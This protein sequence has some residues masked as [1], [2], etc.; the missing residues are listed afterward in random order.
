MSYYKEICDV[1]F[2]IILLYFK[3]V[4][5]INRLYDISF[6]RN[7]L[8]I[9]QFSINNHGKAYFISLYEGVS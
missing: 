9:Y 2:H 4:A 6:A 7:V 5:I 8:L 3:A 1:A